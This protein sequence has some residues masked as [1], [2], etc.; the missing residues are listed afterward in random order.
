[1][2]RP[3]LTA[4]SILRTALPFLLHPPPAHASPVPKKNHARGKCRIAPITFRGWRAQQ[5]SNAWTTLT[6]VPQ[7]GGAA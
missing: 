3:V 7:L 5:L 6:I 2:I 1:V 4:T